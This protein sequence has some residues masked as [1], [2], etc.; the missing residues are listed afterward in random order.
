LGSGLVCSSQLD[1]GLALVKRCHVGLWF[2]MF[3]SSL[4]RTGTCQEMA[5]WDL[6]WYV[7]LKFV[8]DWHLSRDG[9]LGSGMVCSSQLGWGLASVKRGH[10]GDWN[11]MFSQLGW[12]LASVK[13]WHVGDWNGMFFSIRL[14]TGSCREMACWGLVWYVLLN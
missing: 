4:L 1:W 8:E 10:V 14:S 3:F 2:G 9:M 12:G 5:C 13:R 11:G 7:L 6:V